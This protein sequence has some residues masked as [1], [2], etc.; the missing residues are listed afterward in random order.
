MFN[1]PDSTLNNTRPYKGRSIL[2]KLSEYVV[3]DTETTGLSPQSDSIIELAAIYVRDDKIE[4]SFSSLINP[5]RL[6]SPFISQLTGI[7]NQMLSTAPDIHP[8]LTDFLRFVNGHV[9]I[10][11]NVNFD[12][13]FIY[14]STVRILGVPFTNDFLDT[15]RMSR[16]LF[17][18]YRH[19]KLID[20]VQRFDIGSSTAHRAL[21]DAEQTYECY[22]YMKRYVCENSISLYSCN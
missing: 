9:V 12:I 21:L 11:H 19:H 18:Q 6:V 8:V 1:T 7:T 10:G 3:V 13:N 5:H 2:E 20:L 16:R 4:D 22:V 17:P 14:E 15:M